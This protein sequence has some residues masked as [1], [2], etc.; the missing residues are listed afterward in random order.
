MK[1]LKFDVI[2][3]GGGNTACCAALSAYEAGASVAIV[4]AAPRNERG[5]NSRFAGTAWRFPHRGKHHLKPL[6]TQRSLEADFDKCNMLPYTP[7]EFTNDMLTKSRGLHDRKEIETIIKHGYDT[8]RWMADHGVPFQIPLNFWVTKES[9]QGK[10]DLN[11]GVPV[12][13]E[14]YGRGLTD[15]M[16]AAVERTRINVFYDSPGHDLI[17][18]GDKILGVQVRQSQE[19]VNFYGKVILACGGFEANP[20]L[21]RQYLGEG[22]DLAIVRGTRFNTGVMLERAMAAGA[23]AHGHWGGYHCAPLDINAPPV[24]D[25]TILDAWERYSFPYSIMVNTQA[26]RFVDEA[27][28]EPSLTYS[29]MG[30][31]IT[32]QPGGRAYQ[33]FDQKVLHL[34]EPRYRSH[35]TAIEDATIEGLAEKL[36]LDPRML[37]KTVDEFNAATF[38][39]K[40]F[41]PFKLDE[42]STKPSL[43]PR[44]SHWA[45]PLDSPPYVAYAVTTGITF[46]YGGIRTDQKARVLT[47]EGRPMIGLYAAGE[48]TGGF[49]FGYAAGASLIRSSV[50]AKIAGEDAATKTLSATSK[51]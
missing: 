47:N 41:D 48:I 45:Q 33:V 4:E 49:Y 43:V 26:E 18:D 11:P 28:N 31:E 2:V 35:S 9:H 20:R 37:K 44:K 25:I 19:F 27:E 14:D 22:T 42:L 8:V 10:V 24:G 12:V 16:W 30:A 17:T 6:V 36:G 1:Q 5:G 32:K 39:G 23:Q 29:K 13:N 46:T 38:I 21:R 40:K 34:L 7:D 51:I 50:L 15:G 3:V